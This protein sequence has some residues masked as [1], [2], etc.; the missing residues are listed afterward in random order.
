MSKQRDEAS[1]QHFH[2]THK[3]KPSEMSFRCGWDAA[4]KSEKVMGLVTA[5]EKIASGKQTSCLMSDMNCCFIV[6]RQAL[7]EFDG[8][9][10]DRGQDTFVDEEVKSGKVNG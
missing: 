5:L 3:E 4:M 9:W 6:A 2:S 1:S 7:G 10:P 8:V